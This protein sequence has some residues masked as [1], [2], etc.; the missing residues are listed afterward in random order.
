MIDLAELIWLL[1]RRATKEILLM[2]L[3]TGFLVLSI[4]PALAEEGAPPPADEA[5][6]QRE[7]D[8]FMAGLDAAL[9][10]GE[11]PAQEPPA[12]EPKGNLTKIVKDCLRFQT[13][14][15]LGDH[16][17]CFE[18]LDDVGLLERPHE[19]ASRDSE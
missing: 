18:V 10:A 5:S 19:E 12:E 1:S 9:S 14:N 6:V 3:L 4:I 16:E 13:A 15:L 11:G 2:S 8:E 17:E 7:V